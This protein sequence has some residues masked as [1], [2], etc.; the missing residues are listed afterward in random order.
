MLLFVHNYAFLFK[1][2][3]IYYLLF[4]FIIFHIEIINFATFY[5]HL[6]FPLEILKYATV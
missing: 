1:N 5:T 6:D 4:T 3:K 2:M